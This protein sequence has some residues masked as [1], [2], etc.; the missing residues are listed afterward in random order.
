M[1]SNEILRR[2]ACD[3][4]EGRRRRITSKLKALAKDFDLGLENTIE[5]KSCNVGSVLEM[6][7]ECSQEA[8]SEE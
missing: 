3:L 5:N 6:N 4:T 7:S 1:L 2:E 8:W